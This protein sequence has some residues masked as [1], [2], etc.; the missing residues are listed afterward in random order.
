MSFCSEKLSMS[1]AIFHQYVDEYVENLS[2]PLN[3]KI[4]T[5]F[6]HEKR[7]LLT[8]IF[9]GHRRLLGTSMVLQNKLE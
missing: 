7:F 8:R 3:L 4:L 2:K 9:L 6:I 1:T 5:N